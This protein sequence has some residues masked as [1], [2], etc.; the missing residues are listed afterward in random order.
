MNLK[1]NTT[2][3]HHKNVSYNAQETTGCNKHEV[4]T[5]KRK[6]Y[7]VFFFSKFNNSLETI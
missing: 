7:V 3:V 1:T 2:A 6:K 4:A 5:E